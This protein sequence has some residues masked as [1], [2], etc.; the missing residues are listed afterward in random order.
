LL[1]QLL[2]E[3]LL[4]LGQLL[5]KQLLLPWQLR[6]KSFGLYNQL[7]WLRRLVEQ[8]LFLGQFVKK[9]LLLNL[10]RLKNQILLW[11]L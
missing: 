10:R 11:Q 1:R 7:L 8:L 6:S 9:L 4:S 3:Q 5:H 2:S